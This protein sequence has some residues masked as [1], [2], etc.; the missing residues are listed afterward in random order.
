MCNITWIWA[1]E[2]KTLYVPLD[3]CNLEAQPTQYDGGAFPLWSHTKFMDQAYWV[4]NSATDAEEKWLSKKFD[5]KGVLL[6]STFSSLSFPTSFPYN[7]MH[8]IWENL[9]PN[10]ILL[11]T[12][13][14]KGLGAKDC[15]LEK[16]VWEAIG[17]ACA[18][19]SH[20][21]PNVHH[22]LWK[23]SI[24]SGQ[25][26]FLDFVPGT[27]MPPLPF[28]EWLLLSVFCGTCSIIEYMSPVR[29]IRWRDQNYLHWPDKV[30][31]RVKFS[32]QN[33]T[34]SADK[35]SLTYRYYYCYD[36]EWLSTCPLMV[37]ILLH[38]GDS[39]VMLVQCGLIGLFQWNS[40]VENT[41]LPLR[42][43]TFSIPTWVTISVILHLFVHE[44]MYSIDLS[45]KHQWPLRKQIFS[46]P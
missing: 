41:S 17:A 45:F 43:T 36:P 13:K 39:I 8:A 15:Q 6:L 30:G 34:I 38:I 26:L 25:L 40:T 3:C 28:P 16:P 35:V 27:I 7:F 11:W 1:P 46:M 23:V 18:A 5:I 32:Y 31:S 42:V 24:Q 33:T 37:H 4:R 21:V 9:I 12:G 44:L 14:F 10:L 20:T 19:S 22:C 2:D 29:N